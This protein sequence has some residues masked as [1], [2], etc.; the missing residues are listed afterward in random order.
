[1][2]KEEK[3]AGHVEQMERM[4]NAYTFLIRKVEVKRTYET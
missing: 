4:V 3:M 1:V 2:I